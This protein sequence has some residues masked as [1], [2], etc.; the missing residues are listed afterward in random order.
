MFLEQSNRGVSP[1]K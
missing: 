1:A